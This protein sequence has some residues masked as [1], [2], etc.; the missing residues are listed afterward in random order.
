MKNATKWGMLGLGFW[1]WLGAGQRVLAQCENGCEDGSAT[2]ASGAA[3]IVKDLAEIVRDLPA[4]IATILV[5]VALVVLVERLLP[6]LADQVPSRFRL[7]ILPWVPILRLLILLAAIL[8][9]LPMLL[10]LSGSNIIAV[11]GAA[12]L[13]VGFA[14]KD[15]VSSLIAGIVAIV[16]RPYSVGDWVQIGDNYGQVQSM[17]MR[18]LHMVTPDDTG[19]TIPHS[20]IWTDNIANAN[21][22]KRDHQCVANF[23]VEPNHDVAAVRRK[24]WEVGMTSPF[25]NLVD[26]PNRREV[27]VIVLEEP[28]ATHYRLKAYPIDGRDEFQYISDLTTRG[29]AAL[30]RMGVRSVSAPAVP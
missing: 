16:E 8:I 1:L 15:Y 3:A 25:T 29:K 11:L 20:R 30:A 24:L 10:N 17:G 12:G 19:V 14:F 9:V 7:Y 21:G 18:S 2:N 23:Y 13:A 26:G 28:W 6:R 4:I 22:G 27:V 5:A